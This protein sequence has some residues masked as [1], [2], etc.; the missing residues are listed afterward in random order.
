MLLVRL[1]RQHASGDRVI[2][3]ALDPSIESSSAS[4]DRSRTDIAPSFVVI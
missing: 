2:E 1:A 3:P 4:V